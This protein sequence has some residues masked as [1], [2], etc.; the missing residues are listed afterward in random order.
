MAAPGDRLGDRYELIEVIGS[1]ELATVWRA[2]DTR[3]QRPVAIK[4]LRAQFASDPDVTTRF[5]R[6]ARQAAKLSHPNVA[7]VHDTGFDRG[8]AGGTRFTV[9]ELVEGPSAAELLRGGRLPPTLAIEVAIA[10]ARALAEAHGR[11]IVHGAV[12]PGNLIVGLDGP[13]RLADFGMAAPRTSSRSTEARSSVGSSAYISPEQAR[14]EEAT[15]ASDI[16]S[17]GVVLFQMLSGRLPMR[18][19][20]SSRARHRAMRNVDQPEAE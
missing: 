9:M 20:V 6:A 13:V 2:R 1:G 3:L 8:H 7:A 12:K 11:H 14:G 18:T 15:P 19:D 17:L 10:A 4:V 5:E 16:F